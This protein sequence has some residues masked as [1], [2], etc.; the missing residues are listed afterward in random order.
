[1]FRLKS[2]DPKEATGPVAE[3][4]GVFPPQIPVP[5]PM[6]MM[7]ASPEIARL[8]SNLIK[9]F[10]THP[11]LNMGLLALIRY[12][13]AADQDYA[14]CVGF[15]GNMLKMTGLGDVD[16]EAVTDDPAKA[17]LNDKDKAIFL[18]V[19]KALRTPEQI[20][21]ADVEAVRAKGWEDSDIFD[22]MWVGAGMVPAALLMKAL[23][24][25]GGAPS[26]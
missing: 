17:P 22:A 21:D 10:M 6:R 16:L 19:V 4:Y 2:V 13:S 18:V 1:M 26:C 3:A 23:S 7:S 25:P 14:F 20:T 5:L 9:Y 8:Q 11:R 12:I 15:N 24:K